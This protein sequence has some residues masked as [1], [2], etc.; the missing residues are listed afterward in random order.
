MAKLKLKKRPP[1]CA[2]VPQKSAP[3][4][5]EGSLTQHVEQNG[6]SVSVASHAPLS[7]QAHKT[8][9][10]GTAPAAALNGSAHGQATSQN[11]ASA[12][13]AHS[14]EITEK[15]KEL[16]RLA[17]EQGYLTYNDIS[18]ALPGSLV[19][20]ED[21]DEIYVKLRNLEVQIV[22]QAEV[23]RIK[24]ADAD[25]E[26][27]KTRLDILDDPVRMYLRQMGQVPL[28]TREQEVE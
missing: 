9:Q 24:P 12:S 21:L 20:P 16:V 17:Q 14:I 13:I 15:T 18:D 4:T 1:H 28:L 11:G 26:E 6:S 27:E 25:E 3:T 7:A 22:D 8:E 5:S 2:G 19:S 10:N 23:D